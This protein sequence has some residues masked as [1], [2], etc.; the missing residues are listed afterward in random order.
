MPGKQNLIPSHPTDGQ[1]DQSVSWHPSSVPGTP[2]PKRSS[3]ALPVLR[4]QPGAPPA[5]HLGPGALGLPKVLGK[6][7]ALL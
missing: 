6:V 1:V 3:V 7:G 2:D 5:P 4:C